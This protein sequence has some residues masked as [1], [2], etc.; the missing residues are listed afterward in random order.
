ML[1]ALVATGTACSDARL[2]QGADHRRLQVRLAY[3]QIDGG[4]AD[5]GAVKIEANAVC[6]LFYHLFLQ[7]GVST[8][9]ADHRAFSYQVDCLR[10]VLHPKGSLNRMSLDHLLQHFHTHLPDLFGLLDP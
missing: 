4:I 10:Y 2:E 8:A 6:Q 3:E 1:P 5:F 7:A 9:C